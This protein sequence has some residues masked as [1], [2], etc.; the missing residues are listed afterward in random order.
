MPPIVMSLRTRWNL[1]TRSSSSASSAEE[2]SRQLAQDGPDLRVVVRDQDA[3]PSVTFDQHL[4][5]SPSAR[6][7]GG[8]EGPRLPD[9]HRRAPRAVKQPQQSHPAGGWCHKTYGRRRMEP[10]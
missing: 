10:L 8:V 2:T 5:S 4:S 6:Q 1:S 3:R 7:F 9:W